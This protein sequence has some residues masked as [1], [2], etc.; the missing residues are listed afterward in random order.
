M[1]LRRP[2][3]LLAGLAALAAGCPGTGTGEG[4]KAR[5]GAAAALPSGAQAL[6]VYECMVSADK[7]DICTVPAGGGPERRL[8]EH[9]ADDL[10]PRWLRDASGI[11][12]S[13]E[14]SGHWQLW[15]MDPEGGA[16]R[17]RRQDP[18]REWQSDPHPDGRRLAFLS[19]IEEQEESLRVAG[20]GQG[21]TLLTHGPRVVL[22][23]PHWSPDGTR[24][25]F[26]SN[27]GR[28]G[29]KIFVLD[30]ETGEAR[31]ISPLSS[32]ACEPRFSPD[33]RRVA[34][35]RRSHLT[36]TR[37]E[38]VEF[39][40]ASEQERVLVDWPALNYDPT[41]SPDGA[42]LAFVSDRAGGGVQ[43]IYR[44]RLADGQSSRVTFRYPARHPDYRPAR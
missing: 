27:R 42:E 36:R 12:F 21:R 28:L 31:R 7:S 29:H 14:R 11:V 10:Y 3:S 33:G 38:I 39:D 23:N 34:F 20:A 1:R 6:F 22:G 15:Q 16:L 8:A 43:A 26:S 30:V 40:L 37:S 19:G 41:W 35:V 13:S 9:A 18:S 44:L 32:G 4:P 17:Q 25:V 24:I 5:A 2:R